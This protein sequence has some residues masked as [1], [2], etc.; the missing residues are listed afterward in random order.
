MSFT[1]PFPFVTT[2]IVVAFHRGHERFIDAEP[3]LMLAKSN[4]YR[5]SAASL[6]LQSPAAKCLILAS[7]SQAAF[8]RWASQ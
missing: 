6:N 3:A 1:G 2:L 7:T 4:G 5:P 8:S